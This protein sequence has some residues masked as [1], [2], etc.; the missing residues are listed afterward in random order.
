MARVAHGE[1]RERECDLFGDRLHFLVG[2]PEA[3]D[4]PIDAE[5]RIV[6]EREARREV[7]PGGR[8]VGEHRKRARLHCRCRLQVTRQHAPIG[9]RVDAEQRRTRI[10]QPALDAIAHLQ[11]VRSRRLQHEHVVEA[12]GRARQP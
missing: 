7:R 11:Q 12:H 10:A 6:L 3:L 1:V 5:L 4:R 2:V 8:V 9:R